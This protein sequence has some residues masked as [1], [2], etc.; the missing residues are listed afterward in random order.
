MQQKDTQIFGTLLDETIG[1]GDEFLRRFMDNLTGNRLEP[2]FEPDKQVAAG[3]VEIGLIQSAWVKRLY[4][5]LLEAKRKAAQQK[6]VAE[7]A[8]PKERDEEQRKFREL[9]SEADVLHELVWHAIRIEVGGFPCCLE[10]REGWR[11]VEVKHKGPTDVLRALLGG[12]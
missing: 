12:A 7:Y 2:I 11:V 8:R 3:E 5:D 9:D 10:I 6:V 1:P 4:T